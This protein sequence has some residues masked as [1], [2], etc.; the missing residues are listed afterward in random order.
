M[1][2]CYGKWIDDLWGLP[3]VLSHHVVG[4]RRAGLF[5]W[6]LL[7]CFFFS[8][9]FSEQLD[10]FH[11]QQPHWTT[12]FHTHN[13]S[14]SSKSKSTSLNGA[15]PV[16]VDMFTY[17]LLLDFRSWS[18]IFFKCLS[19]LVWVRYTLLDF[20]PFLTHSN[21]YLCSYQFTSLHTYPPYLD[22]VLP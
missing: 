19:I 12:H 17:S 13:Q 15:L 18:E 7:C 4:W 2:A 16:N 21:I 11:T 3:R 22:T 20:F 10:A 6:N 9:S 5:I 8:F 1:N 14:C